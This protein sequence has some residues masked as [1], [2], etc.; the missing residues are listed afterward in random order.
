MAGLAATTVALPAASA[1]GEGD[2]FYL[3]IDKN[4]YTSQFKTMLTVSGTYTCNVESFT[5]DPQF[6]GMGVDVSQIQSKGRIVDGGSG[7]GDFTCDGTTHAWSVTDVYA[8]FGSM[9]EPATWKGGRATAHVGGGVNAGGEC[10]WDEE[11]QQDVCPPGAG[12]DVPWV[13]QIH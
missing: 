4:A 5:P 2:Y 7:Y 8:N 1:Q 11:S 3:T 10:Y 13:I 9:G 6:S 12:D